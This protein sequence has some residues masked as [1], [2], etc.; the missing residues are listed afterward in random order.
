MIAAAAASGTILSIDHTRRWRPRYVHARELIRQ[1]EI[2]AVQRIVGWLGGPRAMLFR[3]GTH[4]IDTALM[5]AESEPE[6][7]FGE[8][9]PGFERYFEYRGDGGRDPAGDPGG[10]V[11]L[12][13]KSGARALLS[14]SKRTPAGFA[15]EVHGERGRL[16]VSDSELVVHLDGAARRVEPPPYRLVDIPAGIDE[17]IRKLDGEPV[18]LACPPSSAREVLQ[19][20]LGILMSHSLGNIR[21]NL[22]DMTP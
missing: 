9:D 22:A 13:L 12:H 10:S 21:V 16:C 19:V 7:V 18:D 8:L 5:L 17:L 6:W 3:N 15:L 11:Y 20:L 2:G 1:G 14:I 4:L